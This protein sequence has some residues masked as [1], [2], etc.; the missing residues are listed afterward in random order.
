MLVAL[1]KKGNLINLVDEI[2]PK[3]KFFCPACRAEVRLKNGTIKIPHFAHVQLENCDSWSEN[4]S[5][6]HLQLKERLYR[7][8]SGT[9]KVEIEYYLPSIRQTPDLLVNDKI[10]IEIQCSSLSIQRLRERTQAYHTQGFTVI[11]LLGENLWLKASLTDLQ[12]NMMYFSEN[13]GFY[14]WEA[15]LEK[16][17]MRL[18]SLI[19]QDL[20]GKAIYL[21]EEFSFDTGSLLDILRQPFRAQK[22]VNLTVKT[23]RNLKNYVQNQLYYCVPKWLKLQQK[24]YQIAENLL[25]IDF[26]QNYYAP[27]GLDLLAVK[28]DGFVQPDFCQISQ[29]LTDY[30][31][32][33]SENRSEKLYPPRYYAIMKDNI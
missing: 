11:W 8:F 9:E 16:E 32:N 33:F 7:W 21:A 12:K 28:F 31:Q 26:D 15:D 5:A 2:P 23:D 30:Y 14:I 22:M 20:R 3:Q 4:E 27:P 17:V 24:Y 19:H 29:N 25:E 6:Q 13:R 10:A 18:K 1:D